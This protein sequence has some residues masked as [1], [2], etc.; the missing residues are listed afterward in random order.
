MV[1]R[2]IVRPLAEIAVATRGI[3]D[4]RHDVAIPD[5]DRSDEI[6]DI[7]RALAF[8][9][10]RS[11]EARDLAERTRAQ[12]ERLHQRTLDDHAARARR[13]AALD[14]LFGL[15]EEKIGATVRRLAAAGPS[16]RHTAANL[17]SE[18]E[19]TER[20][21][22][23]TA[24]V[25]EQS[26]ASVRTIG[27]SGASLAQAIEQISHEADD[28]RHRA[29]AARDATRA[30]RNDAESLDV[31]IGEI[32]IVL[33]FIT[34]IAAQTNLLALNASIEAARAGEAG[35][36]FAVVAEEVKGLARQTQTAAG[37][38]DQRLATI[39]AAADT[40]LVTIGAVDDLVTRFDQSSDSVATAVGRQR[41][42]TRRIA[43]AI[44]DVESGTTDAAQ[45][46]QRL[47]E[48]AEQSRRT[49][50][51]LSRTADDVADG[52][53]TLRGQINRLIADVRAA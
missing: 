46:M 10:A 36:G 47:G 32:A 7:A 38:I 52:V 17:S 13:G 45:N 14:Q 28:S 18:A 9:R 43:G 34:A 53:E 24:T 44:D 19:A 31:L 2:R 50:Q 11:I 16:L 6:G 21:A 51:E 37:E 23:A 30:G 33:D 3:T 12:E 35:R 49:A 40:M 20:H 39:R 26:A 1:R 5:L 15:F 29:L 42:M 25:A 22:L 4:D 48:R 41:D 8:A 27:Q